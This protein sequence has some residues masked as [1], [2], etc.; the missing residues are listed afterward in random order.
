MSRKNP[1]KGAIVLTL[2]AAVAVSLYFLLGPVFEKSESSVDN[3][4]LLFGGLGRDEI[5]ELQIRNPSTGLL[6]K[7]LADRADSW[8][9]AA[10]PPQELATA[11]T[12]PSFEADPG[13]VN[14]ILSTVLA[15]RKEQQMGNLKAGDVGLAPAVYELSVHHGNNQKK[16][17]LLGYDTPVDYLVYAQWSDNPEIFLTSRSLRFGIDKKIAELR[18][19]KIFDLKLADLKEIRVQASASGDFKIL[20]G[21]HFT[22]DDKGSWTADSGKPVAVKSEELASFLDTLNKASVKDFASEKASDRDALGFKKPILELSVTPSAEGAKAQVWKLTQT[23][24]TEEGLKKSKYYLGEASAEATFEVNASLRD[25]FEVDLMKFRDSTVTQIASAEVNSIAVQTPKGALV[26]L[27]KEGPSWKV[28]SEDSV[29]A[30][31]TEKVNEILA[32][33]TQLRAIEFFDDGN[34]RKLG[35]DKPLRIVEISSGAAGSAK[36]HTLFFGKSLGDG[37][38]AINLEG[39]SSPASVKLDVESLLPPDIEAYRVEAPKAPSSTS[40]A[41]TTKG[42][43]VKLETTVSSPKDIRKLPAPIVKAGHKYTGTMKL[44]NGKTLEIEFDAVKAPYTVSNFLHLARN[45]FYDNVVFHRVIRDFVIQGGDPTGTGTGGPGYK[46]DNED[47][48]LKHVRG[49]LSM[50]HAGRNTN[51]SQFFIVLQPQG[52]LNGLHTVF[53][54]VTKGEESLDEVPQG[55]KM[56]TV[57]VFEEAL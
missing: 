46:F 45:K 18:D 49:S 14:G 31:K 48:D 12:A 16:T 55:T 32:K 56:V 37:L 47:N 9:V 52:H 42:K 24:V 39:L 54:K 4:T 23:S 28:R 29:V 21:L 25:S 50:A 51:G 26:T 7:K 57:E 53:G 38:Q 40:P 8:S 1:F 20:K 3:A 43:K 11:S 5:Y 33:L 10:T 2:V 30:A 34:T 17:L 41:P 44:S 15:A 22:K 27:V 36:T 6:V 19:K 13:S 35:L